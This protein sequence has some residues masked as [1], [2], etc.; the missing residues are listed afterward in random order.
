MPDAPQS[1]STVKLQTS[2]TQIIMGAAIGLILIAAGI[3]A[4]AFG[5]RWVVY[6]AE[7]DQR[8][9]AKTGD[10]S[11]LASTRTPESQTTTS[12]AAVHPTATAS[13]SA[14]W[15]T[16]HVRPA[17]TRRIP[18]P[19][20]NVTIR[21]GQA[22][23]TPD[24]RQFGQVV[25]GEQDFFV[26]QEWTWFENGQAMFYQGR[27]HEAIAQFEKAQE[28]RLA[29]PSAVLE[30]WIANSYSALG[31]HPKAIEHYTAA[32]EIKDS[33]SDRIGRAVSY[34]TTGQ[35]ELTL[36]DATA[37]LNLKSERTRTAD[38]HA[39][40]HLILAALSSAQGEYGLTLDHASRALEIMDTMDYDSTSR[41]SALKLNGTAQA[42]LGNPSAAIASYSE[43]MN[44]ADNADIRSLRA[45]AYIES[46]RCPDAITDAEAALSMAAVQDVGYHSDAD[47][48]MVLGICNYQTGDLHSAEQNITKVIAIMRQAG[49]QTEEIQ[50]W[51]E[52]LKSIRGG[53]G[54]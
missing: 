12:Q 21:Q 38:S 20:Q 5:L 47:A 24:P 9:S 23:P 29:G 25:D 3:T 1:P 16:Q 18:T 10:S 26:G 35:W 53:L 11:I 19:T 4:L 31:D 2:K 43:A 41:A 32:I 54:R 44:Y 40:A 8:Y 22:L 48:H 37:A 17:A 6:L 46:D 49:Y 27:Y 42:E 51:Q 15:P 28:V 36:G 39:E 33:S 7:N 13:T 45:L 50:Y 30:S 52:L 14:P 34:A